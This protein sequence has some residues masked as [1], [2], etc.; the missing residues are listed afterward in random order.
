YLA[1]KAK[2]NLRSLAGGQSVRFD[3][4]A[5]LLTPAEA[6]EEEKAIARILSE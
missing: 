1:E 6:R 4:E 5:G 3:C 2:G